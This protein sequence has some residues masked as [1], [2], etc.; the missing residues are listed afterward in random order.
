MSELLN[1][2]AKAFNIETSTNAEL[3]RSKGEPLK[4]FSSNA[5]LTERQL[6]INY[7]A[8][9]NLKRYRILPWSVEEFTANASTNR[10]IINS[11]GWNHLSND[12]FASYK[13]RIVF[14]P[15][16]QN[17]V[18]FDYWKVDNIREQSPTAIDNYMVIKH[19]HC[20]PTG[21]ILITPEIQNKKGIFSQDKS[22]NIAKFRP[23]RLSSKIRT[24]GTIDLSAFYAQKKKG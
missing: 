4:K 18:H 22:S 6:S 10:K 14:I 5:L 23:T 24:V 12:V 7:V 20:S 1:N 9:G 11:H 17:V 15:V 2:I 3:L 8:F 19:R 13:D 16:N 21:V